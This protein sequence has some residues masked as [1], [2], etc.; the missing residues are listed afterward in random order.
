MKNKVFDIEFDEATGGIS[1]LVLNDDETGMNWVIEKRI[2]GLVRCDNYNGFWGDYE[3][4]IQKTELVSFKQSDNG[5]ESL[6]KRTARSYR[7]AQFY[8]GGGAL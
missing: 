7:Q 4:R 2:W 6:F 5:A 8:C 1:S 3:S